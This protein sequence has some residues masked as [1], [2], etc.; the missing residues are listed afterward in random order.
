MYRIQW[1]ISKVFF[2]RRKFCLSTFS[3]PFRSNFPAISWLCN[4]VSMCMCPYVSLHNTFFFVQHDS[5][6]WM[7]KKW[8]KMKTFFIKNF[9]SYRLKQWKWKKKKSE[10]FIYTMLLVSIHIEK[11]SIVKWKKKRNMYEIKKNC[12]CWVLL[13]FEYFMQ[14]N[15]VKN[16]KFILGC[17]WSFYSLLNSL[18]L[19]VSVSISLP[20]TYSVPSSLAFHAIDVFSLLLKLLLLPQFSLCESVPSVNMRT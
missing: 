1:I 19:S 4:C 11:E 12:V 7:E 3:S 8:K 6:I 15:T 2:N 13:L 17:V 18:W 10:L 5:V 9:S 20:L 16:F 14:H